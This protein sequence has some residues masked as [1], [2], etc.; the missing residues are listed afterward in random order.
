M[1]WTWFWGNRRLR[2]R[3]NQEPSASFMDIFVKYEFLVFVSYD[4]VGG[5]PSDCEA[6]N[7]EEDK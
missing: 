4:A 3:R 7:K 6:A 1:L 2:D 5:D